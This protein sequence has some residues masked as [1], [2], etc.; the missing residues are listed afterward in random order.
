MTLIDHEN[1][2]CES[3]ILLA[4]I[5][6][7]LTYVETFDGNSHLILKD[8]FCSIQ[9]LFDEKLDM[10]TVF[11]F[12]IH[13]PVYCNLPHKIQS[14]SCLCQFLSRQ[15]CKNLHSLSI[16]KTIQYTEILF[17]F[18]LVRLGL[19][20]REIAICLYGEEAILD[21][22]DG[23]SDNIRSK[24]RRIIK[25]GEELVA[26]GYEEFLNPSKKVNWELFL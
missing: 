26:A 21:G 6:L 13:M 19:S 1:D 25:L 22:W 11:D 9:L 15:K 14:V 7:K 20:H 3:Q 2:E 16:R 17:A 18:D 24:T 10:N 8:K 23:V 12:E 5:S 4:D